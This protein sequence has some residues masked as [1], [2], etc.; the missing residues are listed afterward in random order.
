ML[1][2][3]KKI[4]DNDMKD[5]KKHIENGCSYG[6]PDGP[7]DSIKECDCPSP[8]EVLLEKIETLKR[9]NNRYGLDLSIAEKIGIEE[10][11][12][13]IFKLISFDELKEFFREDDKRNGTSWVHLMAFKRALDTF[14]QETLFWLYALLEDFDKN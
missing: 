4:K 8:K 13:S 9:L 6:Q 5:S 12:I 7:D 1:W 2:W 3:K 11:I 10:K 14:R